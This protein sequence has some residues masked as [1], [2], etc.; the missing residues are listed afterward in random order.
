MRDWLVVPSTTRLPDSYITDVINEACR[1]IA[2][3]HD[4]RQLETSSSVALVA[5]TQAYALP[6]TFAR[7]RFTYI[8]N[9]DDSTKIEFLN[10]ISYDEFRDKYGIAA[11]STQADPVEYT[12][13][14]NVTA[15]LLVGPTP[16]QSITLWLDYYAIPVDLAA[17]GDSNALTADA[18][19]NALTAP[20]HA[21]LYRAIARASR[22]MLEDERA[23]MFDHE[24]QIELDKVLAEQN[25][26]RWSAKSFPQMREPS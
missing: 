4:L 26:A 3:Q 12:I 10:Q 14:G 15:P 23:A 13:W 19:A 11:S 7:P 21:V 16:D 8:I 9:P 20:W 24:Y 6:A 25:R 17:D 18:S 1:E 2:R 22:F 5:G